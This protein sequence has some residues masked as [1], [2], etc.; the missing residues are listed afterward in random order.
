MMRTPRFKCV[1]ML[2]TAIIIYYYLLPKASKN[3]LAGLIHLSKTDKY[4]DR[5]NAFINQ[6]NSKNDVNPKESV[7]TDIPFENKL[8]NKNGVQDEESVK[9]DISFD[10]GDIHDEESVKTDIPFDNGD[11]HDEESVKTD[12]PFENNNKNDVHD[13]ESVKSSIPYKNQLINRNDVHPIE[14]V[15]TNIQYKNVSTINKTPKIFTFHWF[16]APTNVDL[17]TLPIWLSKCSNLCRY[18]KNATNSD[19]LIFEG[20]SLYGNPP[21]KRR[22]KTNPNQ[23]W[24]FYEM[25]PPTSTKAKTWRRAAWR[26]KFNRT[27]SYRLDSD[28]HTPY[29]TFEKRPKPPMKNFAAIMDQKTQLAAIILSN[30]GVPS[31]RMEYVKLLQNYIPVDVYGRCGDKTCSMVAKSDRNCFDL[32]E[33]NYKFYLS[34]ESA[35]CKDYV[36]ETF[37]RSEALDVVTVVRGGADYSR[38]SP[39]KNYIDANDFKSVKEL[40]SY[41][42]YLDKNETAYREMLERKWDYNVTRIDSHNLTEKHICEMCLK[43]DF[44]SK[45]VKMYDGIAFWYELDK[46]HEPTDLR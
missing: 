22:T 44:W 29:G 4:S 2:L 8:N 23:I 26:K 15:K 32:V 28:V 42:L 43:A 40:A 3:S 45:N 18:T 21:F 37:Y 10:N 19:I 13:G 16:N 14:S 17:K 11:I 41:L 27:I 31:K 35:F 12:I 6:R 7:K 39:E 36:S 34:F 30:C 24:V 5:I 33:Q 9:T 1:F 38:L 25:D 46:C 20:S